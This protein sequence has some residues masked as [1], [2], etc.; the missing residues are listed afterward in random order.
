MKYFGKYLV[1]KNKITACDYEYA[2]NIINKR[3]D[4]K[5]QLLISPIASQ[6][7]VL[8]NYDNKLRNVLNCFDHLFPDSQWIKRSLYFLYGAK[9]KERI[10]G[11]DLMLKICDLAEKK[12]YRI[13]LYGNTKQ[14]LILL[15]KN[16]F[17]KYPNL[18]TVGTVPSKFRRL[19]NHESS[20]LIGKIRKSK[21]DICLISLGSPLQ[22]IF[23]Y[24]LVNQGLEHTSIITVGAAFDFISE[25]KPQAPKWIQNSGFEWLYRFIHEP[26]RLWKRYL[27]Y[28]TQFIFLTM[29]QKIRNYLNLFK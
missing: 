16:L 26:N 29:Q 6:T 15:K 2:L 9:L 10:Y 14:T 27:L 18:L 5:Q 28:G 11:P 25:V 22:E 8:A 4:Q 24:E 13:F 20:I 3:I 12:K 17:K 23:A 7:L 1:L 19:T 21:T